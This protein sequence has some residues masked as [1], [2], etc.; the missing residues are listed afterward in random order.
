VGRRRRLSPRCLFCAMKPGV[1]MRVP[2][3]RCRSRHARWARRP[4]QSWPR[5]RRPGIFATPVEHQ[6]FTKVAD[7]DG[8][9]FRS[10]WIKA[11]RCANAT[12]CAMRSNTPSTGASPAASRRVSCEWSVAHQFHHVEPSPIAPARRHRGRG[13][14]RDVRA[15][16]D[17]GLLPK[18]ALRAR[19]LG[20]APWRPEGHVA[21]EQRS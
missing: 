8:R 16:E 3:P 5:A 9:R 17:A 10:R 6:Y 1:P 2:G 14:C 7:H 21:I 20:P 19:R 18:P 15:G 13:R 4:P 11:G 12:A